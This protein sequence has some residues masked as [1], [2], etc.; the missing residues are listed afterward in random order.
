M[1]KYAFGNVTT[2]DFLKEMQQVT[3]ID[4]SEWKV[5]WLQ[6]TAFK[7]E[8][9]YQSLR[10]SDFMNRFFETVALRNQELS[11]KKNLLRSAIQSQNDFIGQE[12]VYQ[13]AQEPFYEVEDLYAL[14]LQTR[15]QNNNFNYFWQSVSVYKKYIHSLLL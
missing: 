4:L 11:N 14:A 12:A 13:L 7:S 1:K 15:V 2:E 3:E 6:Q 9:A 10:K 5:N 8:E